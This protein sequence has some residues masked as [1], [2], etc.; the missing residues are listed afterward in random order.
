MRVRFGMLSC[1]VVAVV[2][3]TGCGDP[4]TPT[5]T[6]DISKLDSGN[7]QAVPFERHELRESKYGALLEAVRIG[8][9]TPLI[10]D[11]DD[12]FSFQR[13]ANAE[14]RLLPDSLPS[15]FSLKAEEFTELTQ[16]FVTGWTTNAERRKQLFVGRQVTVQILRFRDAGE[17]E[18]AELRLA[19]RQ[20]RNLPGET[21]SVAGFPQ[22][23]AK[24]S[25]SQKYL[26][27]W[28]ADE[29]LLLYVHMDD[30]VSEP[31]EAAPLLD[32]VRKVLANQ[33]NGLESY[34]PTPLDEF[35]SLPID[36]DGLLSRTLPL[37]ASE[38]A[39]SYDQSTVFPGRAALH[40]E[41]RPAV[42]EAAFDDAGVDLV[43]DSGAR[44]YRARDRAGAVRLMAALIEQRSSGWQA[45]DAPPGLPTAECFDTKDKKLNSSTYP[46]VCFV[47]YDRF[48]ALVTG[49]NTQEINQKA[50]AQYKLLAFA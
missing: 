5:P 24:W 18:T 46:P 17:A 33:L 12:R 16:G 27:V 14:R 49:G 47:P 40:L 50:A 7:Y 39:T 36:V 28:L 32:I 26:D 45:R 41:S 9:V 19:E 35:G 21:V 8:A 6:V 42:A 29:S 10:S 38:K 15:L 23:R 20:A 34:T 25:P 2:A 3:L 4:S 22:A 48:I 43:S 30:P 11:A 1:V 44:V 31:P 37:D 13:F